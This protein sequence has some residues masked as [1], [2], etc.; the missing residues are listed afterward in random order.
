V[1]DRVNERIQIFDYEGKLLDIWRNL[2]MPW[3][4]HVTAKDEIWVAGTIAHDRADVRRTA[5]D[6]PSQVIARFDTSGRIHQMQ[7]FYVGVQTQAQYATGNR[8]LAIPSSFRPGDMNTLH[9]MAF[10]SRD[11]LYL[12]NTFGVGMVQKF[13][14]VQDTVTVNA[15]GLPL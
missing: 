11:N 5:D 7:A 12:A 14:P 3:P 8:D 15:K 4:I 10:D 9:G 2:I 13:V 1:A 6:L